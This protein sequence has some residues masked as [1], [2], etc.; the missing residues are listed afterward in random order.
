[1]E[2]SIE[3]TSSEFVKISNLLLSPQEKISLTI[4]FKKKL[5]SYSEYL[6][7]NERGINIPHT[8]LYY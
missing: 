3:Y 4:P 1:M 5:L 7:E 6:N 8:P 2:V